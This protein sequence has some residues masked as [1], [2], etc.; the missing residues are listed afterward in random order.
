MSTGNMRRAQLVSPFGVGA[1]SML[2]NGSSVIT[3]G[4]DHWF[5]S[6]EPA[7]LFVDEFVVPEWRL[8]ERLRV[9]ALRLPPDYRTPPGTQHNVKLS[10]PVLRFPRWCFCIYC[11]RL[12]KTTLSMTQL[13]RCSDET[14]A[15]KVSIHG[16]SAR[17]AD[18]DVCLN[19]EC[20]LSM[21]GARAR[22]ARPGGCDRGA[23]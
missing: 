4:L 17:H 15:G 22:G 8:Q 10:V 6:E 19:L 1:M 3:A 2:V 13:V 21:L 16:V 11:K 9:A 12:F 23:A 20:R 7:N 14:H 5:E 18:A